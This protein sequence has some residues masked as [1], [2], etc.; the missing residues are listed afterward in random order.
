MESVYTYGT[1]SKTWISPKIIGDYPNK[2]KSFICNCNNDGKMYLFGGLIFSIFI[3]NDYVYDMVILDTINLRWEQGSST[4][5]P[6]PRGFMVTF[7]YQIK[8]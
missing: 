3:A 8:K 1:T 4:N 2:K 6:S 5:A 7:Y